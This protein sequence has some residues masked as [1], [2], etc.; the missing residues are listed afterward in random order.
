MIDFAVKVE[1]ILNKYDNQKYSKVTKVFLS[2]EFI[3][4]KDLIILVVDD[5]ETVVN[6]TISTLEKHYPQAKILQ[7]QT[8]QEAQEKIESFQ[9]QLLVMDL[10]IPSQSGK[11]GK[12]EIGIQVLRETME[13][14]PKLNIVVQSA[15]VQTLVRLRPSI[16]EHE[17]GF[18]VA[19]KALSIKEMLTKV[20]WSLQGLIFTP[21][22]MRNG[23][24]FKEE[25][26]TLLSLAF[27]EGLKDKEIAQRMSIAQR[28]VRHY[29]KNIQDALDVYP[30][31]E[32]NVRIQTGIRAREEGLI[33]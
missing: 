5:H 4:K 21:K 32:E 11:K 22:E 7:A 3:M 16:V 18:T 19:D 12:S 29:W 17:G 28:T 20:D 24:E 31:E 8:A 2:E 27:T 33:D 10:S 6:S 1:V 14:Y 9:P 25:W 26:L 13:N 30:Q 15:N 23:L